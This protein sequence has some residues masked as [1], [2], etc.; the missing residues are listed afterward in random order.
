ML[1]DPRSASDEVTR[2]P[3]AVDRGAETESETG[4]EQCET[5]V[6]TMTL[7]DPRSPGCNL[8]GEKVFQRTPILVMQKESGAEGE[9]ATPARGSSIPP[10]SLPETPCEDTPVSDSPLIIKTKAM[11]TSTPTTVPLNYKTGQPSN[12]LQVSRGGEGQGRGTTSTTEW[13]QQL[14]DCVDSRVL[15]TLTVVSR[16]D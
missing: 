1:A 3:I 6:R 7:I 14:S 10:F 13:P 15:S 4:S 2:T 5:P 11:K 16:E 8:G 12:L 9:V